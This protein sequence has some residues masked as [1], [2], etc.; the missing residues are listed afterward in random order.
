MCSTWWICTQ[1]C[2]MDVLVSVFVC[3]CVSL[4]WIHSKKECYFLWWHNFR[5]GFSYFA[6]YVHTMLPSPFIGG[7]HY[8]L[9]SSGGGGGSGSWLI[10]IDL[11]VV[12]F[13]YTHSFCR[14][15]SQTSIHPCMYICIYIYLSCHFSVLYLYSI[16]L[17]LAPI[18]FH[19][20]NGEL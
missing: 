9:H 8:I 4:A 11:F 14:A 17:T 20:G 3:V 6:P 10:F 15:H 5:V 16:K 2:V 13:A 12:V 1:Q 19:G 18:I 7:V